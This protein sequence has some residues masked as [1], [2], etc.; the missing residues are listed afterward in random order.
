MKS[1]QYPTVTIV[2]PAYNQAAFLRETIESVLSQDYPN[3]EYIVIDDGST[4]D[5][6]RVLKEYDGIIKWESQ[7][8]CGQTATINKGW[9]STDGEIITWLNSDDTLLP[10]AVRIGVNFLLEHPETGIVFGD[11]LITKADGTPLEKSPPQ[12]PYSY[13]RFV[14]KCLNTVS[15]PSTFI[16]R[17][18]VDKVGYL[19][20]YYYYFMD[21][22]FWMRAGIYFRIDHIDDVLSTYRLHAES[23][24]I[25]QAKKAAP[26]LEYL[27]QK[28][29]AR[30]DVPAHIRAAEK[31]A[32]MNMCFT[33][34]SYYL[35]GGDSQS[36]AA[37]ATKAFEYNPKGR[38][39]LSNL[40]KYV[41]CRLGNSAIYRKSRDLIGGP[42]P[43]Y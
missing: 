26:E 8:N 16:R 20:P 31:E 29:F 4:D 15:Q 38:Y 22:E 13:S 1:S 9:Q 42:Q 32:M 21:W 7:Q 6:V 27:Y 43:T 35:T 30:D 33:S 36:A 23:K 18:V 14:T 25:A 41:Y 5:T 17:E 10:G 39:Q 34:G 2:T 28:Y 3:I 24:T 19:D 37:M 11:T 40:R 12:P